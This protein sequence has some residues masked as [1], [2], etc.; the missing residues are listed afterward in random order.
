MPVLRQLAE[1]GIRVDVLLF[2]GK[3]GGRV[4]GFKD[5]RGLEQRLVQGAYDAVYSEYFFDERLVRAGTPRFDLS[6]FEPGVRGA[7]G[8]LE[9]LLAVGCWDFYRRYCAHLQGARP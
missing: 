7:V 9:R 8:T 1:A 5:P 6:A 2:G 3:D 4:K